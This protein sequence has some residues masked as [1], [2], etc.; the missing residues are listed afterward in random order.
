MSG[1]AGCVERFLCALFATVVK[2]ISD[3]RLLISGLCAMLLAL[4]FCASAQQAKKVHRIGYLT[5]RAAAEEKVRTSAFL[6]EL[7]SLGY[8]EGK[9][10][11]IEFRR[12]PVGQLDKLPELAAELVRLKV[13]VIIASSGDV[14][15]VAKETTATIPS[16]LRYQRIRWVKVSLGASP[17]PAGTSRGSRTFTLSSS[18]NG[19]NFSRKLSLRPRASPSFGI[20]LA[21]RARS[22]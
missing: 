12:A 17:G 19:W 1:D 2:P 14:G 8:I 4:S 22:N 9:N 5:M 18:P 10:L 3:L 7:E 16:S 15:K 11:V 20:R 13:D 21:P 6:Q